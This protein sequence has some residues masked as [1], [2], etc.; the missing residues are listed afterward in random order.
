MAPRRP[1]VIRHTFRTYS[2]PARA[3]RCALLVAQDMQQTGDRI[4]S[5]E[6]IF[7]G[8]VNYV[9][10]AT[11]KGIKFSEAVR[12]AA[13]RAI[14]TPV[15]EPLTVMR[16]TAAYYPTQPSPCRTA[17]ERGYSEA[18]PR[19]DLS[20][21][22]MRRKLVTTAREIIGMA[23][24]EV[25][26]IACESL[27]PAELADWEPDTTEGAGPIG[28]QLADA[29]A[30]F[31]EAWANRV[32][33]AKAE[34]KQLKY[35]GRLDVATGAVSLAIESVAP[36][37]TLA[38]CTGMQNVIAIYSKRYSSEDSGGPLILQGPAAGHELKAMG[39]FTD[40][41]RLSRTLAEWTIPK[42]L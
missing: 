30:P 37:D 10:E 39:M 17:A 27:V 5:I 18:D 42:I 11:H 16:L 24:V 12:Y 41:L 19:D 15:A 9:M 3:P 26:D 28:L 14:V 35:V 2:A 38:L 1:L 22:D 21:L 34:G 36:T 40:V 31:D 4:H 8:T 29:L 7:S 6:G 32:E 33:E 23:D 20:C 25:T 13:E